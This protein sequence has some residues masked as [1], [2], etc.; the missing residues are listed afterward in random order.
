MAKIKPGAVKLFV[1]C[2]V[3]MLPS[4]AESKLVKSLQ[5]ELSLCGLPSEISDG[6]EMQ[7]RSAKR[8]G[9]IKG[10]RHANICW[11]AVAVRLLVCFRDVSQ[12]WLDR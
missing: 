4:S 2:Q 1:Y 3:K 7:P 11:I 6:N 5:M 9:F 8:M 12:Q 10:D